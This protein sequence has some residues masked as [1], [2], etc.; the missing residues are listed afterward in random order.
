[1]WK[2]ILLSSIVSFG[3]IWVLLSV[4]ETL[5][6]TYETP[7]EAIKNELS[8]NAEFNITFNEEKNAA[9]VIT[10]QKV[11]ILKTNMFGWKITDII[12]G[13]NTSML[14]N[15]DGNQNIWFGKIEDKV[16]EVTINKK[17]TQ[18]IHLKNGTK[19][20]VFFDLNQALL[21]DDGITVTHYNNKNEKVNE[22]TLY[23]Y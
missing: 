18:L 17:L 20:W 13:L 19:Y 7:T 12:E 9:I 23:N 11:I 8:T 16:K 5:A 14:I 6:I 4:K 22:H 1:M 15:F 10:P 3:L 21:K 2:K